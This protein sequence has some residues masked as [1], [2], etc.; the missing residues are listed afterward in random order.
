MS[1][2]WQRELRK[3]F[4]SVDLLADYLELSMEQKKALL[5][6]PRPFTLNVP[7]RLARK[8]EKKSLSDPL[9]LQFVPL[10]LEEQNE[11]HLSKDPVC[12][13]HFRKA[14]KL[15]HKYSGRVLLLPTSACAMHCRFCFRRSFPYAKSEVPSRIDAYL[16]R[17]L[18]YIKSDTSI[19]EVI[20]SGGD[21]LSLPDSTLIP[22]LQ[23]LADIKHVRCIRFHS[24]FI[25]GIP[26]RITPELLDCLSGLN[27]QVWF[28]LHINHAKEMD[29]DLKAALK[30]MQ[31]LGIPILS[32]SVLLRHVNDSIESLKELFYALIECGI[33]PYY[34]H[35]LDPVEGAGHFFV[36]DAKGYELI[37]ELKKQMPGYAVPKFVREIPFKP[38]KTVITSSLL[39]GGQGSTG[40]DLVQIGSVSTA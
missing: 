18:S 17:E 15:L 32:Q 1:A 5:T 10:K 20:L 27:K 29:Q 40:P 13:T 11:E 4:T 30:S 9:F 28:T 38:G 19:E 22:L 16:N 25:V 8:M 26:E 34:L 33:M 12:D 35:A 39:S 2:S 3:N 36:E 24:R 31:V 21:P 37:E 23:K 7:R 14:P 6:L